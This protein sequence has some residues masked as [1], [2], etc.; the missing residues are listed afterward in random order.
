MEYN[1]K[2]SLAILPELLYCYCSG[3]F[4]LVHSITEVLLQIFSIFG[5]HCLCLNYIKLYFTEHFDIIVIITLTSEVIF[6]SSNT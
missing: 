3:L 5:G 1:V 6:F 4:C 2:W